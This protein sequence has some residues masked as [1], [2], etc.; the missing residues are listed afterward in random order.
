M[1]EDIFTISIFKT[2]KDRAYNATTF[3]YIMVSNRFKKSYIFGAM[4]NT[5]IIHV[6]TLSM[7]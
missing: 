7:N 4:I 1:Y 5:P 3:E 2:T 6:H